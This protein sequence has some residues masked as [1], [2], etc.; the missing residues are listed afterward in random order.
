MLLI[1]DAFTLDG[2]DLRIYDACKEVVDANTVVISEKTFK[3]RVYA[4]NYEEDEEDDELV[5]IDEYDLYESDK[6]KYTRQ[7][8]LSIFRKIYC[9][10][11]DPECEED[12]RCC[13]GA[14][15][16]SKEHGILRLELA[17]EA[18]AV[19]HLRYIP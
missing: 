15:K 9:E 17:G 3:V 12:L 8:L 14:V 4:T 7:H 19:N 5:F 6:K 2:S 13:I 1:Y 11:I 10:N 18:D 16:Y